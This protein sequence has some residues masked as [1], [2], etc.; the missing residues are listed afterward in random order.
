M[1]PLPREAVIFTRSTRLLFPLSK[2]IAS[3]VVFWDTSGHHSQVAND[4]PS[5]PFRVE[6]LGVVIRVREVLDSGHVHALA[7]D[8][9]IGHVLQAEVVRAE[10]EDASLEGNR[11]PAR[12]FEAVV[13]GTLDDRLQAARIRLRLGLGHV[14]ASFVP[15]DEVGRR[16]GGQG[17]LDRPHQLKSK[18]ESQEPCEVP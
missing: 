10:V 8:G 3:L 2:S 14:A 18:S 12:G 17:H 15:N 11:C 6:R 13:H 7:L 9:D 1:I 5:G 4:D 16:V